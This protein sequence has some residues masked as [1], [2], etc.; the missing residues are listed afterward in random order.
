LLQRKVPVRPG[1]TPDALADRI[2]GQE[3]I[4]I[5]EASALMA[6]RIQLEIAEKQAKEK[7]AAGEI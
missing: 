3:H 1:D 2:H 6:K 4:A 7:Q 5:V